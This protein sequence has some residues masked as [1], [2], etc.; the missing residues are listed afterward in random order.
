MI[1]FGSARRLLWLIR[2][3]VILVLL[4]G[5]AWAQSVAQEEAAAEVGDWEIPPEA[6]RAGKDGY[7]EQSPRD[8]DVAEYIRREKI[9]EMGYSYDVYGIFKVWDLEISF[10]PWYAR[11]NGPFRIEGETVFDVADVFGV[12]GRDW[13]PAARLDWRYERFRAVV[14]FLGY[15]IN[16]ITDVQEQIEIDDV[17]L[18]IDDQIRTDLDVTNWRVLFGWT[19]FKDKVRK[20]PHYD[21]DLLLGLNLMRFKGTVN[22]VDRTD[23]LVRFDQWIPLPVIGIAGRYR[24][25]NFAIEGEI[26]GLWIDLDIYGGATA[27]ARVSAAWYPWQNFVLRV[28]YRS[29][30]LGAFIASVEIDFAMVGPFFEFGGVW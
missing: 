14:D 12:N 26:T 13:V 20:V 2:A 21:V 23:N 27:D 5:I 10:Q 7:V 3:P 1:R 17:V 18:E 19:I 8:F 22:I 28:G 30:E 15:S 11:L 16:G 4:S 24:F 6:P 25:G 9:E 29:L